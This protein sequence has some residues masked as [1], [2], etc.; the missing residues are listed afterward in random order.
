MYTPPYFLSSFSFF[1]LEW[2]D[3][4]TFPSQ[5]DWLGSTGNLLVS[6]LPIDVCFWKRGA[7]SYSFPNPALLLLLPF[8]P[9]F[10]LVEG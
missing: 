5:P 4:E 2:V 7:P 1:F 6:L 9:P 8:S 10:F 3:V